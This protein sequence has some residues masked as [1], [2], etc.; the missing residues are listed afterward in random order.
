MTT[1]MAK[2]K[3]R[4]A[5]RR[6]DIT[7]ERREDTTEARRDTTTHPTTV[8]T[9]TMAK[10]KPRTV[11]RKEDTTEARKEDTTEARK[12]SIT[13]KEKQIRIHIHPTT[14]MT[15][16]MAKAKPRTAARREDITAERREDTTEVRRDTTNPARRNMMMTSMTSYQNESKRLKKKINI[17]LIIYFRQRFSSPPT[18]ER[19]LRNTF[20]RYIPSYYIDSIDWYAPKNKHNVKV[21]V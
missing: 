7:A 6:E 8:M 20:S 16:T 12:A 1:T 13:V 11:A 4:T 17:V 15:T 21:E 9:T 18:K 10:A 14:A 3:P 19:E 5:A 2:A